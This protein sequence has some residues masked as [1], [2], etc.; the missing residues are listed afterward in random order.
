MVHYLGLTW[1]CKSTKSCHLGTMATQWLGLA[2]SSFQ[3][4]SVLDIISDPTGEHEA[5][6]VCTH[7]W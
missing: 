2:F 4:K 1:C 5:A 3:D 7:S 6:G